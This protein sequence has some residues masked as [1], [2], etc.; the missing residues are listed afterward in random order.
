MVWYEKMHFPIQRIGAE[1]PE[2]KQSQQKLILTF[3]I[4][5]SVV[6]TPDVETEAEFVFAGSFSG[7][8]F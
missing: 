2:P 8:K 5:V 7:G 1:T 6:M 4:Q 3:D